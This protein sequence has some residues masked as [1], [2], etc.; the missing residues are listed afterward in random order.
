MTKAQVY[1][2]TLDGLAKA[3]ENFKGILITDTGTGQMLIIETKNSTY[4]IQILD[5]VKGLVMVTGGEFF[6]QSETCILSGS[7]WGGHALRMRWIG[8]GMCMEFRREGDRTV[9]TS[10]VQKISVLL[11][12]A[13]NGTVH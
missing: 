9:T 3:S 13:P 6:S 1:A 7:T 10:S 5:P 11:A 12:S 2:V 8:L 4:K